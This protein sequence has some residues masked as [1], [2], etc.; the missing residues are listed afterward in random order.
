MS[1]LLQD[2][3]KKGAW[4]AEEDDL[5]RR[6]IKQHGPKNWSV[7]A[8]GIIGRSGKSC[9]LRWC[10]QLNPDVKKEPFSQ[11][12][13][14]IVVR[15]HKFHGNKWAVI[16]K[17]LPGR[18]DNAVKN[19]WNSTLKRKYMS[20]QLENK[21]IDAGYG[22]NW[23]LANPPH[24]HLASMPEQ[25]H[26]AKAHI[27]EEKTG[28][29]PEEGKQHPLK[30]ANRNESKYRNAELLSTELP[31]GIAKVSVDVAMKL[32]E[33]LPQDTQTALV[34]ASLL[35]A[36]AFQAQNT[37]FAKKSSSTPNKS[38]QHKGQM[39]SA[40]HDMKE[41]L[42][43]RDASGLVPVQ[44]NGVGSQV[45]SDYDVYS[46]QGVIAMMDKMAADV[47]AQGTIYADNTPTKQHCGQTPVVSLP[48]STT[49]KRI[50]KG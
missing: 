19:H 3:L 50:K 25:Q 44:T 5:L 20:D 47:T 8:N 38:S 36:P 28:P 30:Q 32:L 23:L 33:S 16:A 26:L 14:A 40:H 37:S 18:T 48:P 27:A 42:P 13:D 21:Y 24:E 45:P 41:N 22:L 10:N 15:A 43:V 35:A 6:L 11:W 17:L 39:H 31:G 7:I 49:R 9:R 29:A 2:E 12:E 34:E 4:T 1:K 46:Q